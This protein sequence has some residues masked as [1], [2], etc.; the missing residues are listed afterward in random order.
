MEIVVETSIEA[1]KI[2]VEFG[3]RVVP[4]DYYMAGT[5]PAKHKCQGANVPE[6]NIHM[7]IRGG[8]VSTRRVASRES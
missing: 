6:T 1:S 4:P 8:R 7:D 2:I 3:R 5:K